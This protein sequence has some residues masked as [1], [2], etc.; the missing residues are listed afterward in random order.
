VVRDDEPVQAVLDRESRVIRTEDPLTTI[1]SF[2][3]CR[4]QAKASQVSDGRE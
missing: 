3:C 1:G 4:S 2:V